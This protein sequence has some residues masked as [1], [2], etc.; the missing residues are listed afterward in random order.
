MLKQNWTPRQH[1]IHYL[2][3]RQNEIDE[4]RRPRLMDNDPRPMPLDKEYMQVRIDDNGNPYYAYLQPKQP[5]PPNYDADSLINISD[6]RY[7]GPLCTE[8]EPCDRCGENEE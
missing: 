7:T 4:R 5:P 6:G 8:R 2:Q 3:K 1:Q